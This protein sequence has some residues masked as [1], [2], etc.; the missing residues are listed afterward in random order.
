LLL[1]LLI[2]L[3]VLQFGLLS[4]A[5][6]DSFLTHAADL[7]NM[8]QPIWNTLHGRLLQETK[9]DGSEGTRLSD[10][11]EPIFVPVS[12]SF[13]IW[14]DVRA[15]LW[16]QT[17]ALALGAI[18]VYW[19][20]RDEAQAG[21]RG[22][23]EAEAWGVTFAALYLLFPALEW[24]N[25][26][27]FHAVPLAVAP[28]LFALHY[29]RR[30]RYR[31]VWFFALIA[32]STQE[33]I[34]LL[35]LMIGLYIA[36]VQRR[37]RVGLS[38]ATVSV[39]WFTVATFVIIPHFAAQVYRGQAASVYFQRFG[40]LG[41][42]PA[43][44]ARTV[45]TRPDVVLRILIQPDRLAYVGGLLASAGFVALLDPVTLVLGAPTLGIN[46]LSAYYAQYSGR[47]HYSAPLVP[48]FVVAAI[49]GAARLSRWL[50]RH[51]RPSLARQT[52]SSTVL[53]VVILISLGYHRRAGVTPLAASFRWPQVTPHN[54]LLD[55][56]AKQIPDT[57]VLSA[58]AQ[59]FPHFTHRRRIHVFP[60]VADAEYVLLDV[61][62]MNEMHPV[63]LQKKAL[64]LVSSGQ[65]GILDAADGYILLQRGLAGHAT[66]PDAFYDFA[67]RAASTPQ[68][69]I[70]VMF[71]D[72]VRLVGFDADVDPWGRAYTR[73]YWR[74][75]RPLPASARPWPFF[76]D[77]AGQVLEDTEIRPPVTTVWY[78]AS[79]WQVGETVVVETIPWDVGD[80]FWV[81]AGFRVGERWD[82]RSQR[83]PI[84]DVAPGNL[85][86]RRFDDETWVRLAEFVRRDDRLHIAG[87]WRR[88]D[89]P[90]DAQPVHAHLGDA[91][92]L[93]GFRLRSP[94]NHSPHSP[95]G[96]C[97][98]GE[99]LHLTLYWR[100]LRRM[101]EDYTVFVHLLSPDGRIVAQADRQ[102][103]NYTYPTRWWV[104][105]EVVPDAIQLDVPPDAP[106]GPYRLR[107]GLYRAE[108]GERLPLT[109]GPG[110]NGAIDLGTQ[111]S[112]I[113]SG[114]KN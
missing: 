91:V 41:N 51:L 2:A 97:T 15:L 96:L 47:Y 113:Q 52:A 108:T 18:P 27:E 20:A 33:H 75:L 66:L 12:L 81:A 112:S 9:K 90:S 35:T 64:A 32:M 48:F 106:A 29:T 67:R 37:P 4:S 93:E 83:L 56:F 14:N 28:L 69:S 109:A 74:V 23:R 24:A 78:P 39:A 54:R 110:A 82:D 45:F 5:M 89:M 1:G 6:H 36:I 26:T 22:E 62:G 68:Y 88:W 100:A 105:N 101:T 16:L 103:Q 76:V 80:R 73:T 104:P 13:L 98:A 72:A 58:T 49:I 53:A 60:T 95:G 59:L 77:D 55:R 44:I 21:A 63:A 46:M 86:L 57:A 38:L 17:L 70:N 99:P 71:G 111:C 10:H 34:P 43:D 31:P 3:Y 79:R 8:D 19:I 42:T 11:F 114:A 7:G 50:T 94:T 102:P 61:T 30:R 92:A 25:I 40:E 107:V 65:F 87:E 84:T 85:L